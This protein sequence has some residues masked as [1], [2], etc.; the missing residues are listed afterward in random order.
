MGGIVLGLLNI[1][2]GKQY[3]FALLGEF[4]RDYDVGKDIFS[5]AT[6]GLTIGGPWG[7]VIGAAAGFAKGTVQEIINHNKAEE[8]ARTANLISSIANDQINQRMGYTS[9]KSQ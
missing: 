6:T 3:G 5:G 2:A 4:T 7:A 1:A 8:A 9:D